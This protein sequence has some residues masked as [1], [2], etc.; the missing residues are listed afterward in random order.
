MKIKTKSN[1]PI[2]SIKPELF[3]GMPLKY[4]DKEV[5]KCL[6]ADWSKETGYVILEYEITDEHIMM[7]IIE[8]NKS[9]LAIDS[10][11]AT[12]LSIPIPAQLEITSEDDIHED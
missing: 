5:G 3:I 6:S 10:K 12:K 11:D 2:T 9:G 7:Q 8:G 4:N 1:I